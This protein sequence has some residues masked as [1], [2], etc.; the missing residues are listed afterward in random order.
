MTP[1]RD[2]LLSVFLINF[3]HAR[4]L[5]E[6]LDS[7]LAQTRLPDEIVVCDDA[8]TDAS[9]EVI[10]AYAARDPRIRPVRHSKNLG[11]VCNINEALGLVAGR[12]VMGMASDDRL[13][14]HFCERCLEMLQAHPSV[15]L[16]STMSRMMDENGRDTG[17]CGLPPM[18]EHPSCF[19]ALECRERLRSLG[20]WILGNA[21]VYRR[22]A[23]LAIGGMDSALHSYC[24][25]FAAMVLAIR[26]GA[27]FI[28]EEL[29]HWR[30]LP[31]GYSTTLG[32]D[33]ERGV[34]VIL[35][36]KELMRANF[37]D[38]FD[39]EFIALW[40]RRMTYD[41][42]GPTGHPRLT[43]DPERILRDTA[44]AVCPGESP[45]SE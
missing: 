35:R 45:G 12:Y 28:P 8:S 3:N 39:E 30:L 18:P 37:S 4:Y 23:L 40:Q 29:A 7:L 13:S 1:P 15:A 6:A 14:P 10:T 20:P 27:A 33:V 11:V 17:P 5:P 34:E 26:H 24:D 16:C 38:L 42:F 31:T 19:T 22:E 41:L 9:W 36:A 43:Q 2:L 21:T 32:R 44:G 25:A